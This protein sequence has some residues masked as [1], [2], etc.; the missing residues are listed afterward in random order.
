[1]Q[2][3]KSRALFE[4]V[5]NGRKTLA[6][7]RSIMNTRIAWAYPTPETS[8]AETMLKEVAAEA[9]IQIMEH[10]AV[11]ACFIEGELDSLIVSDQLVEIEEVD[12]VDA[13]GH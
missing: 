2:N 4:L 5:L 13:I 8:L 6:E 1:M 10:Q 12:D 9:I 3:K 11:G 7:L